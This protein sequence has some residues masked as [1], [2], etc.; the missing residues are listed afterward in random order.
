MK[1]LNKILSVGL[2]AVAMTACGNQNAA[3]QQAAALAAAQAAALSGQGGCVPIQSGTFSF[4]GTGALESD[5]QLQV[6]YLPAMSTNPGHHGT[7]VMGG[8][9][10]TSTGMIQ[11]QPKVSTNGTLQLTASPQG[12]M[13][14]G[15]LQL[16]QAVVQ[17]IMMYYSGY[18]T[19]YNTGYTTGYPNT[20]TTSL[21]VQSI[22]LDVVQNV[23]LSNTGYTTGYTTGY[24][25]PGYGQVI[26]A[27]VYLTLSNGQTVGPIALQ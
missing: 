15:M 23:I 1:A 17:Q 9:M 13:V 11:Y 2:I 26:Q 27:L 8:T 22:A 3:Q 5:A 20:A 25:S 10:N 19:G 21:C 16:N 7:V 14:S 4:T 12:G 24:S 6:G 18:N